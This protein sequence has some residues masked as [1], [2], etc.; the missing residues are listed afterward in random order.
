MRETSPPQVNATQTPSSSSAPGSGSAPASTATNRV[1][2]KRQLASAGGYDAQVQMLAADAA[3]SSADTHAAAA[4]GVSGGGGRMPHADRIQQSFGGYDISNVQAHMD[5]AATQANQAMGAEAYATGNHIAFG[6]APDLHTAAHEAAHVVQ[7]RAGVQ[8][9]GGVGEVGDPYEVHADR[10]AD[11]VVQGK[12]AEPILAE[13][14]GGPTT[15]DASGLAVQHRRKNKKKAKSKKAP[16][17]GGGKGTP[18]ALDTADDLD[19]D[20]T[21][22]VEAEDGD[23]LGNSA[24]DIRVLAKLPPLQSLNDLFLYAALEAQAVMPQLLAKGAALG[25]KAAGAVADVA[26]K[27]AIPSDASAILEAEGKVDILDKTWVSAAKLNLE[28]KNKADGKLEMAGKFEFGHA[29]TTGAGWFV[30]FMPPLRM[31]TAGSYEVKATADSVNECMHLMKLAVQ[32]SMLSQTAAPQQATPEQKEALEKEKAN[33][34]A[35]Q[36]ALGWLAMMIRRGVGAVGTLIRHLFQPGDTAEWSMQKFVNALWHGDADQSLDQ[37]IEAALAE[38]D[39]G[40]KVEITKETGVGFGIA[41]QAKSGE[42][43][44]EAE[45]LG[46]GKTE[47]KRTFDKDNLKEGGTKEVTH[48]WTLAAKGKITLANFEGEAEY[49]LAKPFGKPSEGELVLKGVLKVSPTEAIAAAIAGQI[50]SALGSSID[51]QREEAESNGLRPSLPGRSALLTG[52]Q[53]F[54]SG[55]LLELAKSQATGPGQD[56]EV[57]VAITWKHP[58]WH[59]SKSEVT[60]VKVLKGEAG[61]I[62]KGEASLKTGIKFGAEFEAPAKEGEDKKSGQPDATKKT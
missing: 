11:A 9:Y 50:A 46:G 35:L 3:E 51:A 27:T 58:P 45:L 37:S 54:G 22:E 6:G 52:I 4:S 60:A 40:D 56:A 2:L 25:S 36:K 28:L 34:N 43:G 14:A 15:S 47:T 18:P 21:E 19:T 29:G 31:A 55:K 10:V 42:D 53:V 48:K 44:V 24:E 41:G 8:L 57:G 16:K 62:A 32:Q 49:K 39:E 1:Q 23:D 38:M 12:S 17:S 20:A 33:K 59:H 5:S 13:M 30:P 7:Q 61:I 26:A